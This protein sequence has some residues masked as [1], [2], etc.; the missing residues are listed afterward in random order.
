M[1]C[2]PGLGY[3]VNR[4]LNLSSI[5]ISLIVC[6]LDSCPYFLSEAVLGDMTKV[7]P[8]RMPVVL[9]RSPYYRR[10]DLL[11]PKL[12]HPAGILIGRQPRNVAH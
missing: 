1:R 12:F 4:L 7:G 3:V 5:K 6:R 9:F 8:I 2:L 11:V 10:D